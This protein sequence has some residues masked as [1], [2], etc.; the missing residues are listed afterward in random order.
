MDKWGRG[1]DLSYLV[2]KL[3]GS[4]EKPRDL[5]YR[6]SGAAG[7]QGKRSG[8]EPTVYRYSVKSEKR[9][10]MQRKKRTTI[11]GNCTKMYTKKE[12]AGTL[13]T[14][15]EAKR[16]CTKMHTKKGAFADGRLIM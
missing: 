6:A 1:C 16:K 2:L 15:E 4:R 10:K 7:D 3:L 11:P 8:E 9:N 5:V 13:R 12:Y 14:R